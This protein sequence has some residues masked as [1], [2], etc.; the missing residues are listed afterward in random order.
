MKLSRIV[1]AA[2]VLFAALPA[3][4]QKPGETTYG[5]YEFNLFGGGSW[6]K[7][8]D[9]RPYFDLGTGGVAGIRVV[10]NYWKYIAIEEALTLHGVNNASFTRPGTF[11]SVSFGTRQRQ[12]MINPVFHFTP[13]EARFRPFVTAGAGFNWLSPTDAADKAAGLPH[14]SGLGAPVDLKTGTG[15]LLNY[16]AGLKAKF[17]ERVG[18][19]MDVRGFLTNGVDMGVGRGTSATVVQ[20]QSDPNPLNSLQ[21]TGGL[22]FYMGKLAEAPIGDFRAGVIESSTQAACPGDAI[23]FRLPVTNTMNGMVSKFKWTVDG[24]DAGTGDTLTIRAPEKAGTLAARA[25]VEADS[26]QIK[27]KSIVKYLRKNPIAATARDASVRVKEYK[28]PGVTATANPSRI[29][30]G[31][32]SALSASPSLSEC[33][34]DVTYNWTLDGGGALSGTGASRTLTASGL[35]LACGTTRTLTANV[36]IRDA[37]GATANSSVPVTVSAPPCPPPPPPPPPALRATQFDDIL[38]A[39]NGNTRVNN[40]GKRTLDR[41]YEQ[42]MASGDYDI[43]L[44]GHIDSTES[45]IRRRR[46]QKAIDRERVENAAAYLIAGDQPCKRFDRNRVKVAVMGDNQS[47][48][49]RTALCEDSVRERAGS[50]VRARDDKAKFRRVEVWLVPRAGKGELPSGITGIETAPDVK[51]CPK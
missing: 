1:L 25:I 21:L 46:N 8:Q 20:F 38:F 33:S 43:L 41:V 42:A 11:D 22:T 50:K 27:D 16:G 30:T 32:T 24:K 39:A 44:V 29:A 35:N 10:Q 9:P 49:L 15:A 5:K 6:F 17:M 47:S 2:G 26:S 23:T 28:A 45:K 14:G 34:G 12:F 36:T 40:C 19:R 4:A 51:G 18:L 48:P 31:G 37:K 7:R 3:A 13:R